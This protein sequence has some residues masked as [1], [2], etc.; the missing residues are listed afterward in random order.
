MLLGKGFLAVI[1]GNEAETDES[2]L[3]QKEKVMEESQ[4]CLI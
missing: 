1:N 3:R 4:Y 2:G